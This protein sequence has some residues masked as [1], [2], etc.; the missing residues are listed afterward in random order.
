M[1]YFSWTKNSNQYLD[2]I[3]DPWA[4]ADIQ[5]DAG[6]LLFLFRFREQLEF[7]RSRFEKGKGEWNIETVRNKS[8]K[9]CAGVVMGN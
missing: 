7:P 8:S 3:S 1:Y 6:D 5:Y 9:I 2:F 4:G